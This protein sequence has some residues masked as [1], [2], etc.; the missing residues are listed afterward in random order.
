MRRL[1]LDFR[2]RPRPRA[3]GWVLLGCGLLAAGGA[4]WAERE[5]AAETAVHQSALRR[6]ERALPQD[7]RT[8]VA[9]GT[10]EPDLPMANMQRV[11]AQLNLPWGE[12]FTTLESLVGADV[13]LLSLTPDARKRQVRISGEA[14]DLA[15]MLAFHRG[16]EDSAPLRDVSLLNHEFAEQAPGRPVRFSLVAAWVI[17]DAHP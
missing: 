14:R 15:A 3:A 10:K 9:S 2:R 16:L 8:P 7:A 13:A 1:E 5:I 4:L 17:D 11:R 12:L 6:A